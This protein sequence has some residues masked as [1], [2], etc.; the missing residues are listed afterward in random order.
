MTAHCT[1]HLRYLCFF[2]GWAGG[3]VYDRVSRRT[4][5]LTERQ[6][7]GTG[8]GGCALILVSSWTVMAILYHTSGLLDLDFY[9]I[10]YSCA[11]GP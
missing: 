9:S 8:C 5:Y 6:R 2:L 4:D 1:A 7:N 10:S 3:V 11:L